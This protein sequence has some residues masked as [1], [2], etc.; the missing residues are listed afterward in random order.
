MLRRTSING[1]SGRGASGASLKKTS[2]MS[3][4]PFDTAKFIELLT[5]FEA[6][7]RI[8]LITVMTDDIR[9]KMADGEIDPELRNGELW[10]ILHSDKANAINKLLAE[11]ELKIQGKRPDD[12]ILGDSALLQKL[13]EIEKDLK[14]FVRR[15]PYFKNVGNPVNLDELHPVATNEPGAALPKKKSA[16]SPPKRH[17]KYFVV[18]NLFL[19]TFA[20]FE[21]LKRNP[22]ELYPDQREFTQKQIDSYRP[23]IMNEIDKL[24]IENKQFIT[25]N[26]NPS[27]PT[28]V[29]LESQLMD[30]IGRLLK[31]IA[32]YKD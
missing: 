13:V 15:N 1:G 3:S 9:R 23:S 27:Y 20:A 21:K 12:Y 8:K 5:Y 31:L 22:R 18:A 26:P 7:K 25:A 4:K 17:E 24:D 29:A 28:Q 30:G 11:R 2:P 32:K 16:K 14:D 19:E 10:L 6:F